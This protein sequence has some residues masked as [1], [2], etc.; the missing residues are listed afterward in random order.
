MLQNLQRLAKL[1]APE[2]IIV[3]LPLIPDF[4]TDADRDASEALLRTYGIERFDRFVYKTNID[5]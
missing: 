4:N 5:K 3:R 2:R 1:I